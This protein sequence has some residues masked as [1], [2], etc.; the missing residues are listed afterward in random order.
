MED[1]KRPDHLPGGFNLESTGVT[2]FPQL[3]YRS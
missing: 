1:T 3:F 2:G